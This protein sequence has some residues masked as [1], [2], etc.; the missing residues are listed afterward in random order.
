MK[1]GDNMTTVNM[2]KIVTRNTNPKSGTKT[3][4]FWRDDEP[5]YDIIMTIRANGGDVKKTV[6]LA[7]THYFECDNA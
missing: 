1:G 3:Y 6:E 7:L 5:F 2:D 4:V